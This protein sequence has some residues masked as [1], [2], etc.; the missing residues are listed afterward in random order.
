MIGDE[1]RFNENQ[2]YNTRNDLK[3]FNRPLIFPF[4]C[5]FACPAY[6]CTLDG[7]NSAIAFIIPEELAGAALRPSPLISGVVTR[8]VR[9]ESPIMLFH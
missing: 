4:L 6:F 9:M 5:L 1:L 8:G 2:A 3:H 7:L